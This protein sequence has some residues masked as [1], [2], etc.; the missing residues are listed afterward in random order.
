[1]ELRKQNISLR[2]SSVD[3]RKI[4]MLAS[5]LYARDSDVFRFAIKTALARLAPL[6]ELNAKG[7][8]LLPL[9]TEFGAE[10]THY[11]ELDTERLET[12]V[13]AGLS[14]TVKR[15]ERR[16]LEL[17]ALVG[18]EENYAMLKLRE[19]IQRP[20]NEAD[21]VASML[22]EY[23]FDKYFVTTPVRS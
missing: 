5:R 8:E 20:V 7:V 2:M 13:N 16:D 23:L 15:V 3:L 1:M 14:D 12:I 21:G 17:L 6:H 19:L 22:R 18:Q 4:K 11:F 10:L 9:F